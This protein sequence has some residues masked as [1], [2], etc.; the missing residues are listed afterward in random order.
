M[1]FPT[2]ERLVTKAQALAPAIEE[3]DRILS[4][5]GEPTLQ[6]DLIAT[7]TGLSEERVRSALDLFVA[8]DVLT[9]VRCLRCFSDDCGQLVEFDGAKRPTAC[10]S[11][12][13]T[14]FQ[15]RDVTVYRLATAGKDEKERVSSR[16]GSAELPDRLEHYKG[17]VDAIVVTMRQADEFPAVLKRFPPERTIQG[18]R[19]YN[20]CRV[21]TPTG[22]RNLLVATLRVDQGEGEAIAATRDVIDDLDPGMILLVGIAGGAPGEVALGDVI[23]GSHVYD[24]TVHAVETDQSR[25]FSEKGGPMH[26]AV[27]RRI[28]NLIVDLPPHLGDLKLPPLP[29]L[30]YSAPVVGEAAAKVM[31][32]LK[33]RYGDPP[34]APAHPFFTDGPIASSDGRIQ[35]PKLVEL[36][37]GTM[38]HM[39]AIEMELAGV[40][41]GARNAEKETPV[42]SI[43][44]ISDIVGL[45]RDG[46]WTEY[47]AETA[48]AYALAFLRTWA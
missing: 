23:F 9:K 21:W 29:P 1:F 27:R 42:L 2:S 22:K 44:A 38:R 30:D 18:K 41:R 10:T 31:K 14:R 37:Q 26:E 32:L 3:I 11:C 36:W 47:A 6:I 39:L 25:S 33:K 43:R 34:V 4:K 7:K 28:G 19:R 15:T 17:K 35:D 16:L 8:E 5:R 46:S 48:A 13:G 24:L 12:D 45:T 20:F 40:Y